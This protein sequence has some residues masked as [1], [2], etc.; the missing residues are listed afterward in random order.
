MNSDDPNDFRLGDGSMQP[1]SAPQPVPV[2]ASHGGHDFG[3]DAR[4]IRARAPRESRMI[5]WQGCPLIPAEDV[6]EV[7]A[8]AE[9]RIRVGIRHGGDIIWFDRKPFPLII[10]LDEIHERWGPE[11][12]VTALVAVN[13]AAPGSGIVGKP[14][15]Q[16]EFEVWPQSEAD[17]GLEP[18]PINTSLPEVPRSLIEEQDRRRMLRGDRRFG[19]RERFGG[20]RER[21]GGGGGGDDGNGVYLSPDN[22]AF[23]SSPMPTQPPPAGYAWTQ[24]GEQWA[25]TVAQPMMGPMLSAPPEPKPTGLAALIAGRSPE[26]LLTLAAGAFK[27]LREV[28]GSGDRAVN[29][30]VERERIRQEYELRKQEMAQQHSMFLEQMKFQMQQTAAMHVQQA[31]PV[32]ANAIRAAA[33]AEARLESMQRE[34]ERLRGEI[35][36]ARNAPRQEA[37]DLITQIQRIKQQAEVLGINKTGGPPAEPKPDT[38]EQIADLLDT[39]GGRVLVEKLAG[40]FLGGDDSQPTQQSTQQPQQPAQQPQQVEEGGGYGY[41]PDQLPPG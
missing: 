37:P 21:F 33:L 40:R 5:P 24:I 10:N 32:D 20:E 4:T 13:P 27:L 22:G 31:P 25:L 17:I 12:Y 30:D 18:W 14:F 1:L 23:P 38:M 2:A 36:A 11:R 34:Q 26:E 6:A 9:L 15:A 28:S 29:A 7:P 35:L 8:S 19:E 39:Q 41:A 3:I 16:R